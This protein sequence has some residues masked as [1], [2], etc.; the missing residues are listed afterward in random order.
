MTALDWGA[1]AP[2]RI[3]SRLVAEGL[4]AG[5]HLSVR[6]GAG[7]EFGGYREYNPGDD[8]RFLDRR[9]LLRHDRL[10]VRQFETETERAL[11]IVVDATGSMA[12]RGSRAPGAKAAMAAVLAAALA[13]VVV[14][15]GDPVGLSYIG[16]EVARPV[17]VGGGRDVTERLLASLEELTPGGDANKDGAAM[18]DRALGPLSRAARRGSVVV[19]FSDL[20]DLP[21]EAPE[22]VASIA[23]RGRAVIVVQLLDPDEEDLPFEGTV[24]LRGLEGGRVVETY[25]DATRGAYLEALAKLRTR[26]SD[27]VLARGGRFVQATTAEDPVAILRRTVEAIR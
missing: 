17:R 9:A 12:Y 25:V 5:A 11:R 26:W 4:Y 3:R 10:L 24:R 19:L 18:L 13:R 20:L 7:V 27:V 14:L 1:L 16:G 21:E 6:R 15:G 22:R 8:L 2:L 23:L